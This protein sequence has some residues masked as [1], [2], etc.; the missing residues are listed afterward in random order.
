LT[1]TTAIKILD[2]FIEERSTALD[3]FK[4]TTKD[5]EDDFPIKLAKAIIMLYEQDI[6]ISLI[7]KKEI[8][9]E[10]PTKNRSKQKSS[11]SHKN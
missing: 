1:I 11:E 4:E 5:W 9:T 10:L 6:W 3:Q 7:L 8:Q 2:L